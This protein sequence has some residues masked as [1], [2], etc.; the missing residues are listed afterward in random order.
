[1][2]HPYTQGY[3]VNS[4]LYPLNQDFGNG[5]IDQK[6]FQ[7]DD[8]LKIQQSVKYNILDSQVCTA[9]AYGKDYTKEDQQFIADFIKDKIAE[10]YPD[11]VNL[12]KHLDALM[13]RVQEDLV[14]FNAQTDRLCYFHVCFP[15]NWDPMNALNK[16]FKQI[17]SKV[18]GMN[19]DKADG[20]RRTIL[21]NGPFQRFVWDVIFENRLNF[22]PDIHRKQFNL[23]D[24]VVYIK[25]ERQVIKGFVDRGLVLL[26][27]K[28]YLIPF[29]NIKKKELL[30]TLKGM[31]KEQLKYK[32]L[33]KSVDN[34]ISYLEIKCKEEGI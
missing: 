28:Q 15:N 2:Y 19:L 9:C 14:I 4:G 31:T 20:F 8:N 34:L 18:P 12:P 11:I 16:D 24:P 1:M 25:I 26:F 10:E 5:L 13:M 29:D 22:H 3:N 7:I 17:H 32:E 23:E 33:D 30:S 21:N 6:F 27:I